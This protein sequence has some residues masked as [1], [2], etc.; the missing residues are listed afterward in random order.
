MF[1]REGY[2]FLHWVYTFQ[3]LWFLD[4][5]MQVEDFL[6]ALFLGQWQRL[7]NLSYQERAARIL[8]AWIDPS[9]L[10]PSSVRDMITKAYSSFEHEEVAPIKKL[11]S[12]VYIQELFYGPTASFKDLALQLM[13]RI[14]EEAVNKRQSGQVDMQKHRVSSCTAKKRSYNKPVDILQ[15]TCYR[16]AHIRMCSHGLRQ[17]VD[18]KSVACC[19]QTCC[20]L[21]VKTYYPQACCKLFPQVL[22][23]LQMTCCNNWL[24]NNRHCF[25]TIF[26]KGRQGKHCFLAMFSKG[27]QIRKH[28]FLAM[29]PEGGQ[30][31]KH[32]FLAMFP[33]VGQTRK[34][35]FLAMFPE[36]GQTKKHCFLAMFPEVGQTRKHCFLAM[37]SEGG[38]T[39][40]HCLLAMF[41]KVDKLGNIVS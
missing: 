1:L 27:G 2:H 18:D 30:I 19:Q 8:E 16:Q 5:L 31:R 37:L 38:Q 25:R 3:S 14:F 20:K 6:I 36:V 28:F 41:F 29:F 7:I 4:I 34:H 21:V 12:G 35:C 15:Q 40:K 32:C 22:T 11:A 33:E 17:L 39:R 10:H 23:S 26:S 9:E 24:S 13:P